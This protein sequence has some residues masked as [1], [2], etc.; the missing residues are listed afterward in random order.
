M[1]HLTGICGELGDDAS[2][3]WLV[4]HER[5]PQASETLAEILAERG[6]MPG[7]IAAAAVVNDS[8]NWRRIGEICLAAGD[9]SGATAMFRR[10]VAAA[11]AGPDERAN[12]VFQLAAV[13]EA[14]KRAGDLAGSKAS[15]AAAETFVTHIADRST[16]GQYQAKA[17]MINEAKA[18]L[19]QTRFGEEELRQE[20]ASAQF[21]SGDVDGA[22]QTASEMAR[23]STWFDTLG[24]SLAQ[25]DKLDAVESVAPKIHHPLDRA[26]LF[27]GVARGLLARCGRN[28]FTWRRYDRQSTW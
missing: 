13:G 19:K 4:E 18:S 17:G 24:V 16:L 7:A 22:L 23:P 5:T 14:Q 28:G 1:R 15:F 26:A 20:L 6:D 25:S 27:T 3:R 12:R 9:K 2:L 21:A 10:A 11:E 8:D